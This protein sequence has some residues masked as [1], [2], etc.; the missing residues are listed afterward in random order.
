MALPD[1]LR[2]PPKISFLAFFFMWAER[3]RWEVPDLHIRACVFLQ[4]AWISDSTL[5]LL[6]LPRGHAKSTIL[7][8]FNAWI[9]YCWGLTRI[10]HQSESDGTALKTSRGTQNVLRN[11][12]LTTKLLPASV[13]T[14]E[15]W[16]IAGAALNDARNASMYARGILSNTTSSRADFI[17]NDDIEVPGNI[18]TPE[19]RE[20]LRFRLGEQIHIAVPGA[21]KLYI[22]TPHTHDS[23]YEDVK[24]QGAM[25]MV[26]R[27]FAQEHRIEKAER[28]RYPIG[29]V[30]EYVFMGIGETARLLREGLDYQ[31]EGTVLVLDNPAGALIDCYAGAAWP[32]RFD[33]EEMQM[34]RQQTRTIGEWDSQYQLHAKPVT[35]V[36]LDPARIV[37]YDLVP[38]FRKAN[39]S[40]AM[41]LGS[42]QI[43]GAAVRW[44]PAGGKLRSD[45][46]AVA[47]VLQ[48]LVGRRYLHRIAAL[49]GDVAEFSPDGKT[50]VGGQV[51][52]LCELVAELNLPRIVIETN[53]IGTFAPAVLKAALKQRRLQCGVAEEMA[54]Q[55]KN[56]RILEAWEP[57]L[58]ANGQLWAHVDVLKGPLWDQMRDWKPAVQNQADDLLDAGAGALTDTPERI[59]KIVGNPHITAR[60][61]WRTSEGDIEATFER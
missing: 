56:R 11:H 15:Q 45:V 5:L 52:Q 12:P 23:I 49:T 51:F 22:G 61:D 25:A 3:M 1:R 28:G 59:A 48:D 50:I 18:G 38:T 55:N 53:G 41:F 2:V 34:R 20:K 19:A 36:R 43:A 4:E 42:V 32:E 44:D 7:E 26:V 37:P 31:L 46:S 14:I 27:M 29:F 21:P 9:Y 40:A 33:A 30:P 8:V 39:G 24:R 47:V 54:V 57:L 6:M 10:L 16:W 13:G 58:M 17:Q 60:D 35:Q